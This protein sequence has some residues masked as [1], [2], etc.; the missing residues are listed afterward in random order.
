MDRTIKE[1]C[2]KEIN[3]RAIKN[4]MQ[5]L[6][7]KASKVEIRYY[8][9]NIGIFRKIKKII[10]YKS[11]LFGWHIQGGGYSLS[12]KSPEKWFRPLWNWNEFVFSDK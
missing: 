6:G 2:A 1:I 8:I 3:E 9:R 5:F 10:K 11:E 12:Y 4:P 7:T